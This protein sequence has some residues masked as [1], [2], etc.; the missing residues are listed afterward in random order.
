[1]SLCVCKFHTHMARSTLKRAINLHLGRIGSDI[2]TFLQ[3]GIESGQ[4]FEQLADELARITQF[5]ISART[6]RRWWNET[7]APAAIPLEA[8]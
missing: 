7:Q 8:S 3:R 1:M 4:G 6:L 2:D 5:P